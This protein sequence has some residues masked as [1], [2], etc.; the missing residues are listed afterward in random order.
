MTKKPKAGRPAKPK[1]GRPTK[2]TPALG[3]QICE[4]LMLGESLRTICTDETMPDRAT[5]AR[6][7]AADRDFCDQYA[8]A[9]EVQADVLAD[10]ALAIA[11]N[12]LMGEVVTVTEKPDG[13]E[14][15]TV[16]VDMIEHRRL[17]VDARK[18]AAG[19]LAP[20]KYGDKVSHEHA[21]EDGGPIKLQPVINLYGRPE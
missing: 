1:F 20:K 3:T 2:F 6:W 13:P 5:V 15:K 11:D 9:R 16:T 12:Q 18:W 14:M 7:L 21:G 10:E 19:K 4:R 17:Q 8:R